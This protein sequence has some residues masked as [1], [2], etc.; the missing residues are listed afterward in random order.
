MNELM[1]KI[2]AAKKRSR[3]QLAALPFTEK[4]RLVEMMRDRSLLIAKNPLRT[5]NLRTVP[6]VVVSGN[7]VTPSESLAHTA[8]SMPV[9]ARQSPIQANTLQNVAVE[10]AESQLRFG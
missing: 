7:G 6:V 3:Q 5:Q 1:D 4:V 2:L 8:G 10:A 9:V